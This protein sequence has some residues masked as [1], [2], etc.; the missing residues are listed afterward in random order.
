MNTCWGRDNQTKKRVGPDE[1]RNHGH[2][3][4]SD[5]CQLTFDSLIINAVADVGDSLSLSQLFDNLQLGM[6]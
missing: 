4:D 6:E 2:G 3:L 1:N 5:P